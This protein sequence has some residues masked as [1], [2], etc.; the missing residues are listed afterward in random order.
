[1]VS[2]NRIRPEALQAVRAFAGASH[3][4]LIRAGGYAP[5]Q[6]CVCAPHQLPLRVTSSVALRIAGDLRN[7]AIILNPHPPIDITSASSNPP[8]LQRSSAN[9]FSSTEARQAARQRLGERPDLIHELS[10]AQQLLHASVAWSPSTSVAGC[11]SNAPAGMMPGPHVPPALPLYPGR[12]QDNYHYHQ[13]THPPLPHN[14]YATYHHPPPHYGHPHAPHYPQP[15][16]PPYQQPQYPMP[17]RPYQQTPPHNPIVVSSHPHSQP[18][19]PVTRPPV[20]TPPA[21]KPEPQIDTPQPAPSTPSASSLAQVS[22]TSPTTTMSTSTPPVSSRPSFSA[23]PPP[24]P[25]PQPTRRMPFY[26]EVRIT[27]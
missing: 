11:E 27:Y 5:R 13:Q 22:P 23:P 19:P 1:M 3:S 8:T 25:P 2:E 9:P 24:P 20:Q 6:L 21:P 4:V 16:Y 17:P 10:S 12:R 7:P 14:P 18:V 15:W 26:P